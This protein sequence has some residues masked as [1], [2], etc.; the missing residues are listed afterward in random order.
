MNNII[1]G[2]VFIEETAM[3]IVIMILAVEEEAASSLWVEVPQQNTEPVFCQQASQV[4]S[5]GSFANASFDVIDGDLFHVMNLVTKH[6]S[7]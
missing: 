5:S 6:E 7:Q 1:D 4:Y 3:R 2:D